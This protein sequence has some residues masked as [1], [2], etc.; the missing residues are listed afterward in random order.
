M[1]CANFWLRA[2]IAVSLALLLGAGLLLRS[3]ANLRTS[4]MGFD[5]TNVLD[6]DNFICPN[7]AYKDLGTRRAFTIGFSTGSK[8]WLAS[9]PLRFRRPS[10]A[11]RAQ[12]HGHTDGTMSPELTSQLVEYNSITPDFFETLPEFR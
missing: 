6:G 8:R 2:E 7:G 9:R 11:R 1:G 12:R 5:S 10:V 3:F 4:A